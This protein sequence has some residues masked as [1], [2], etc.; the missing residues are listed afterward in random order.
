[1]PMRSISISYGRR[2]DGWRSSCEAKWDK[3]LGLAQSTFLSLIAHVGIDVRPAKFG[4]LTNRL[5]P[6]Q[7]GVEGRLWA[8]FLKLG[9][10]PESMESKS[11]RRLASDAYLPQFNCLL[12]FD[13]VQHFTPQRMVT[14]DAMTDAD[15]LGFNLESYRALCRSH[16][17]IAMQ[18]GAGGFRRP[19]SEFPFQGGRHAQRAFFDMM[20]DLLPPLHGLRPTIRISEFDLPSLLSDRHQVRI[21]LEAKIGDCLDQR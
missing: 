18:K 1:M 19:T 21:E 3:T 15:Q 6:A 10:H 11:A 20:R 14:L 12:E 4:W 8:T 7:D 2:P 13:E 17:A 9:G 16:S 5:T